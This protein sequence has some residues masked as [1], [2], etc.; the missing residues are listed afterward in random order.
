MEKKKAGEGMEVSR[1]LFHVGPREDV[2][3]G[4][5]GVETQWGSCAESGGKEFQ[6]KG[7]A[8]A[9]ARRQQCFSECEAGVAGAE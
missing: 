3:G 7:T 4:D 8:S 2:L 5:N 6:A 9:K 1:T